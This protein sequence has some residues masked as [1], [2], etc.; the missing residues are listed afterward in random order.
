MRIRES[1]DRL[2]DRVFG[3][4]AE[5]VPINIAIYDHPN[6]ITDSDPKRDGYYLITKKYSHIEA[7]VSLGRFQVRR[8]EHVF[9][10]WDEPGCEI[11]AWAEMPRA[12]EARKASQ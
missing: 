11:V 9:S 4:K 10:G 5:T 8:C 1:I 12:Y 7:T 3:R 6:W 2:L